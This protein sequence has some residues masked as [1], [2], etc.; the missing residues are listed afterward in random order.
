[1][2]DD[3]PVEVAEFLG[4]LD[5]A[6]PEA[7]AAHIAGNYWEITR[8][9]E[10]YLAGTP[11]MRTRTFDEREPEF[12]MLSAP[13]LTRAFEAGEARMRVRIEELLSIQD[14]PVLRLANRQMHAAGFLKH[15]RSECAEA[16]TRANASGNAR[17]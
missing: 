17:R 13:E 6:T 12:R 7:L 4:A 16:D 11:L 2:S 10:T 3:Q 8:H 9:V 1:M 5:S 15:S 14:N